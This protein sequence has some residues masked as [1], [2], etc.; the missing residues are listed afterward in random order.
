MQ[1]KTIDRVL[2]IVS[3]LFFISIII[4][5]IGFMINLLYNFFG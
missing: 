4:V 3:I 2:N 1:K 5:G